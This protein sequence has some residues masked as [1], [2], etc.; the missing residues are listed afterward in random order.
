MPAPERSP[1]GTGSWSGQRTSASSF[2]E[3]RV[4]PPPR[5]PAGSPR[6]GGLTQ[7]LELQARSQQTNPPGRLGCRGSRLPAA[8]IRAP[9]S[10]RGLRARVR[11]P[12][13][14]PATSGG[15]ASG[16][17]S[18]RDRPGCTARPIDAATAPQWPHQRS[19]SG[20]RRLDGT[21][22]RLG[23]RWSCNL[24]PQAEA[25]PPASINQAAGLPVGRCKPSVRV[26]AAFCQHPE[27]V[28][29]SHAAADPA[30][31][32]TCEHVAIQ[33]GSVVP[34]LGHPE[35]PWVTHRRCR[36]RKVVQGPPGALFTP[37]HPP[38]G[39]CSLS[40][41]SVYSGRFPSSS[42]FWCSGFLAAI[43]PATPSRQ[44]S[45]ED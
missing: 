19:A 34:G 7:L 10:W 27:A 36:L 29:R 40:R 26:G 5:R 44:G 18:R 28:R 9:S 4:A 37:C 24:E 1:G 12:A 11:A 13:V 38:D 43:R 35:W 6:A 8:R 14:R 30:L 3:P 20:R 2:R 23:D 42:A 39:P 22:Q 45:L 16:R 33:G 41:F 32:V 17:R 21:A 25:A 15:A 31:N